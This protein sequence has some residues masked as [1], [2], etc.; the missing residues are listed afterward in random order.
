[1]ASTSNSTAQVADWTPI[2]PHLETIQ[3]FEGD[4][5]EQMM[6]DFITMLRARKAIK[7]GIKIFG[8]MECRNVDELMVDRLQ[9]LVE[10]VVWDRWTGSED[11]YEDEYMYGSQYSGG[12]LGYNEYGTDSDEWGVYRFGL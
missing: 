1:M 8:M 11:G 10:H 2:F 9:H 3:I 4:F 5:T 7:K 12:G 6:D